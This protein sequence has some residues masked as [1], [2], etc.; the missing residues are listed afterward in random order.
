MGAGRVDGVMKGIVPC[1]LFGT[2]KGD[3]GIVD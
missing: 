3:G 2:V 1:A